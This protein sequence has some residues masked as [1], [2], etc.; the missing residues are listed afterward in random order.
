MCVLVCVCVCVCVCACFS[1]FVGSETSNFTPNVGS[2]NFCGDKL[3]N[4]TTLTLN[5]RVCYGVFYVCF[6]EVRINFWITFENL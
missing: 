6:K 1:E 4:P 3:L 5:F 2:D